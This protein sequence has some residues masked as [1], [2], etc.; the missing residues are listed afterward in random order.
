MIQ[1][2]CSGCSKEFRLADDLVGKKV[3]CPQ[4][5]AVTVVPED[6]ADEPGTPDRIRPE[7]VAASP[8]RDAEP[9]ESAWKR[10]SQ[11]SETN[12]DRPRRK[13]R[14]RPPSSTKA[15]VIGLSVVAVI[16]VMAVVGGA[17]YYFV[18]KIVSTPT[19]TQAWQEFSTPNGNYKVSMPGTP[20]ENNDVLQG[21]N[22]KKFVLLRVREKQSFTVCHIEL[23]GVT[24]TPGNLNMLQ[25]AERDHL[26]QLTKGKL[27]H[28]KGFELQGVPGKEFQIVAPDGSTIIERLFLISDKNGSR[29]YM[30]AAG[31]SGSDPAIKTFLDSFRFIDVRGVAP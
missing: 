13:L 9:A 21:A 10:P 16:F 29:C 4:C 23:P 22:G 5:Q 3:R 8:T 17:A 19:S 30:L 25:V 11:K 6:E 24:A 12:P 15:L 28:E 7:S 26:L 14:K 20:T 18:S 1:F 31:G 2:A 27:Q